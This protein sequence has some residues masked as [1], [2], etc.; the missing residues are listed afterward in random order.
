MFLDWK[1]RPE[2]YY[3]IDVEAD[4]LTPTII[5]CMCWRNVKTKEIGECRGHEETKGFF[6]KTK[7]SFYIGHNLLKYD[8]L[9]L[10]RLC[11]VGIPITRCIDTL[12]LSTLYSP[13]L[14]GGHSLGAWGERFKK[15]KI[16]FNDFSNLSEE[17]VTYCHMDVEITCELFVRITQVLSKIG[18]S[19]KS[20]DIQHK[21]TNILRKQQENGFWFDG[22][23]ALN[24]FQQLRSREDEI[25]GII[26][27]AFPPE[28]RLVRTSN[29][30]TKTGLPTA[31]Y[32]KDC[33]RYL[34]EPDEGQG[35]YDAFEEVPFSIG[36]PKQRVE[37]LLELGWVADEFTPKGQPKATEK[38]LV[39]FAEECGVPEVALITKW[40][41]ING[42]ANMINTW[43]DN[44]NEDTGCIHG[45]LFVADTLRF[46]HQRPNTANVPAVR[47][48][49]ESGHPILGEAG[50]FTYESR[51]LWTA[52]P[53]R[54]LVGTDASG[55]ELR[56]LA[57][58]L[59]RP[60]FTEQVINGDPHSANADLIGVTRSIAKTILYSVQYGAAALKVAKTLGVTV[61][62]GARLRQLLLDKL[63]LGDLIKK[64][65]AEQARGRIELVDGSM[66]I[67]PSPHAAL[68]Y[69]LQGGGA[70][71]MA[72]ASIFLEQEIRRK[73]LNSLLVGSIHDEWQ[74][75]V[76][77]S[78]AEEHGRLAI[79]S[80]R[81]AGEELNMNVPLDGT[82]KSGRTWSETH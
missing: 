44:W 18:F 36:S 57:H 73:G 60:E 21:I 5:W 48:A 38:S 27:E 12:I 62:E 13:S 31:I 43:L 64:C 71:V 33:G 58:Y 54:V 30:Y 46:R 29:I 77:P 65:Q 23:R 4:S 52:R 1:S 51:D 3:V 70:R 59:E 50:Y 22:P 41:A 67:C 79:E 16:E 40:M 20:I 39:A 37:K 69:K 19:E 63:G 66:I 81:N 74:Y 9:A 34:V 28:R 82:S 24:L 76:L 75:D 6:E 47:I 8:V 17:M 68:N 55:L 11:G 7:G 61:K 78:D 35:T 49:K 56:M 15:P 45:S 42:R 25:K 53:G 14:V 2:D 32:T 80:I 72:Q 26:H 10:N